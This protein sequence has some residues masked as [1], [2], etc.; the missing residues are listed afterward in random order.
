MLLPLSPANTWEAGLGTVLLSPALTPSPTLPA[1]GEQAS[2]ARPWAS[3]P[4][5]S[6]LQNRRWRWGRTVLCPL[7]VT[8]PACVRPSLA[9][10]TLLW[11]VR[12]WKAD[13]GAPAPAPRPAGSLL[14]SA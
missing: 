5:S 2:Y 6:H 4:Q 8:L 7:L 13:G 9:P 14:G 1:L 10:F 12:C 11:P 3:G